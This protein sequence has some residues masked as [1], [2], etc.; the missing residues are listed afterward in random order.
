MKKNKFSLI[1]LLL[2]GMIAFSCSDE[3]DIDPVLNDVI[4]PDFNDVSDIESV[5]FGVYSGF[6]AESQYTGFALALGDWPADDLK[7]AQQN[8][9]QGAIIH[10][11]DYV[12]ST[13]N[14]T[15]AWAGA[16]TIVRRANFVIEGVDAYEGEDTQEAQSLKAEA[17]IL[18]A[19]SLLHLHKLFGEK[20]VDGSE[21]SVPY[22]NGA[23]DITKQLGRSTTNELLDNVITDINEAIP[24]LMDSADPN[25]VTHSLAY[26]LLARAAMFRNRWDDVVTNCTLSIDSSD[27]QISSINNFGDMWGE[28]DQDGEAIFK[29][30]LN[31]DD[32]QVSDP[33][34]TD[35]VGPRFDA[36]ADLLNLYADNDV[37]LQS[38]FV[39]DE[40]D[41]F[42]I[43]KYYGPSTQRGFHEPFVMRLS[44][45]YLSRA[46]A[47]YELGNEADALNDLNMIRENRVPDFVSGNETGDALRDAIRNERRKEFAFEGFRF[48]DLKRWGQDVV[49]TDCTADECLLPAGDFR[50]V[51][52]IPQAEMFANQNMVQNTGY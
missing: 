24:N 6:K 17:Q 41:G 44:E 11:W 5:L 31:P 42:I 15:D 10:E 26:G 8:T 14:T 3:L 40:D 47:H 34:W 13:Q 18:K 32:I 35:G 38:Y 45:L 20:F 9:G 25:R 22:V 46:E 16:Y 30:A 21:L 12:N 37:R 4:Q 48:F 7:I 43:G 19:L 2:I 50:F 23:T 39:D 51:Y 33:Y 36:T 49:R 52:P 29:L 28:S 27:V 1:L